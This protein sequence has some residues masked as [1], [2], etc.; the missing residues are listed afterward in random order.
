MYSLLSNHIFIKACEYTPEGKLAQVRN[1]FFLGKKRILLYTERL[2]FYRRLT[3]KGIHHI[4]FY[5]LPSYPHFYAE[6]SNLLQA[7]LI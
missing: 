7:S 6:L 2:H 5:Q 3:I 1:R 4:V